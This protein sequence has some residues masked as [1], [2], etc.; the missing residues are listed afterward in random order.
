MLTKTPAQLF[1]RDR[2]I[3]ALLERLANR[4]VDAGYQMTNDEKKAFD[5]LYHELD[6]DIK[7]LAA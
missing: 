3:Q 5:I 1:D 6:V 4:L 2:R 7:A